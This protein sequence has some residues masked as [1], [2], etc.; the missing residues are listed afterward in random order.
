MY[1]EETAVDRIEIMEDGQ[2]QIRKAIR[3][4]KDGVK[5]AETF[6]RHVVTPDQDIKGEHDK[7]KLVA[8]A[9]WTPEVIAQFIAKKPKP[10]EAIVEVVPEVVPE[11]V[12]PLVVPEE[13][14][15]PME[16]PLP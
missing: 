14:S 11:V 10:L 7:V 1:T 13:S 4:Y 2:M 16:E 5:I 15:A 6:H 12:E 3:V 9:V 8:A